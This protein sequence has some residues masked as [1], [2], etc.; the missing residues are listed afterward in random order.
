MHGPIRLN[1]ELSPD[2]MVVLFTCKNDE[3]SI[4]NEGAR[5][6]KTLYIDFS[7]AQGQPICG[8]ILP[9][10]ELI[11]AF[12]HVLVTCKNEEDPIKNEG[13]RVFTSF[14]SLYKS[15]G[16]FPDPQEQLTT[17]IDHSPW[18]DLVEFR[19]RPFMVV[20]VSCNKSCRMTA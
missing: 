5:E 4:K 6:F 7:D 12:M 11:K 14:F 16:I 19:T 18:S 10:F 15:M 8:G 20:L 3:D 9:K 1:L 2:F 13:A 17:V